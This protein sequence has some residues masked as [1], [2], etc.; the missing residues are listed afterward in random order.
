MT[1]HQD[2][3]TASCG[4]CSGFC[5]EAHPYNVSILGFKE[6]AMS[7]TGFSFAYRAFIIERL[8]VQECYS[9]IHR[10]VASN[11]LTAETNIGHVTTAV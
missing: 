2:F 1:R 10:H 11:I 3:S 6:D 5:G 8:P 7:A 4:Q 9:R